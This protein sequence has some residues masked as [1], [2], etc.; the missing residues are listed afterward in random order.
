MVAAFCLGTST[1]NSFI[2]SVGLGF[3][4]GFGFGLVGAIDFKKQTNKKK[5]YLIQNDSRASGTLVC[6]DG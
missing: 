3:C 6:S 5:W 1:N 4:F 2:Q